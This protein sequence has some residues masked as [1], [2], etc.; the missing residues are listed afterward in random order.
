MD[1]NQQAVQEAFPQAREGIRW[2]RLKELNDKGVMSFQTSTIELWFGYWVLASDEAVIRLPD[3]EALRQAYGCGPEGP[4]ALGSVLYDVLNDIVVDVKMDPVEAS[5]RN[6]PG[7][8]TDMFADFKA[9]GR[10][11]RLIVFDKPCASS[12][13]VDEMEQGSFKYLMRVG[14]GFHA[15]CDLAGEGVDDACQV[16][17]HTARIVKLRIPGINESEAET[18]ITNLMDE[19]LREKTFKWLLQIRWP[20]GTGPGYDL[21]RSILEFP[22]FTGATPDTVKQDFFAN[23]FLA[24]LFTYYMRAQLAVPGA[25]RSKAVE[26][27]RKVIHSPE[28][29]ALR[30][31]L[32][33]LLVD[34]G[35]YKVK[36]MRDLRL[37]FERDFLP[38]VYEQPPRKAGKG[39]KSRR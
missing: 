26:R 7:T 1:K 16:A 18:F 21:V 32:V 17:G 23:M 8:R 38:L 6:L 3:S 13:L 24:N 35:V 39:A 11:D 10:S 19:N 29:A 34:G 4:A 15:A 14:K 22:N 36:E 9:T 28:A 27:A 37:V 33:G 5:G 31:Q 12:E 2:E 25:K 20:A 30:D